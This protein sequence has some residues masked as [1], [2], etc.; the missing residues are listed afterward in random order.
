MPLDLPF[1]VYPRQVVE[2]KCDLTT[3]CRK[4]TMELSISSFAL[5]QHYSLADQI[6]AQLTRGMLLPLVPQML[7]HI[8]ASGCYHRCWAWWSPPREIARSQAN[9]YK[10]L[11]KCWEHAD[12]FF[13]LSHPVGAALPPS[14]L[15]PD[16]GRTPC[17]PP[18]HIPNVPGLQSVFWFLGPLSP[19]TLPS[20]PAAPTP[21]ARL[22]AASKS[23]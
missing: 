7:S 5:C 17:H 8:C 19:N 16:S 10:S 13:I 6:R 23:F 20:W 21:S 18:R 4:I 12:R 11:P 14:W 22:L 1:N 2:M 9:A 3:V 15:L